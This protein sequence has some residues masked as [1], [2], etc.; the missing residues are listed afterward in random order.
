MNCIELNS[1]FLILSL[2]Q[3]QISI[4]GKNMFH[5]YNFFNEKKLI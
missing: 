2:Y 5:I 3:V 4:N 1:I